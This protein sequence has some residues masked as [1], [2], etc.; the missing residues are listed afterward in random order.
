MFVQACKATPGIDTFL[1]ITGEK[2][3][4]ITMSGNDLRG[5]KN[6]VKKDQGIVIY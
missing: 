1:Q 6:G 3:E 4:S 5:A 2:S